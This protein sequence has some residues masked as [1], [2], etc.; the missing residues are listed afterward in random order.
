M[1]TAIIVND[2][3]LSE[4]SDAA[5]MLIMGDFSMNSTVAIGDVRIP[6]QVFGVHGTTGV[7]YWSA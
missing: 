6:A 4:I 5:R 3:Q 7:S 2:V 1:G